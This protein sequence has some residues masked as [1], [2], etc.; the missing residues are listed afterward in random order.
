ML[1]LPMV[2]FSVMFSMMVLL[3]SSDSCFHLE[4][5]D[6]QK[7]ARRQRLKARTINKHV[8]LLSAM[9]R[10]AVRSTPQRLARMPWEKI[11]HL[12]ES[13]SRLG[14]TLT[15]SQVMDLLESCEGPAKLAIALMTYTGMRRGSCAELTW[16]RID[17][18]SRVIRL[19][20]SNTKQGE[21]HEVYFGD[22]LAEIL[23]EF[24]GEGRL[25]NVHVETIGDWV[26]K[27]MQDAG[28]WRKGV[29]CHALRHAFVT[30]LLRSGV[31]IQTVS[32]M[33]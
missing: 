20:P 2:I 25:F 23:E 21:W 18:E 3:A 14:E 15:R 29:G 26:R 4:F 9:L 10:H 11:P 7:N 13:D 5:F 19:D 17:M 6:Y 32:N 22:E 8:D 33:A 30:D 27:S 1:S 31:D 28:V 24:R 16:D 12:S